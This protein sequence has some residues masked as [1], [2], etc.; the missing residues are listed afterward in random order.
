MLSAGITLGLDRAV[1]A[2]GSSCRGAAQAMTRLELLFGTARADGTRV[3]DADWV[4]FLDAE[5]TPRFP[6]GLTVLR[7]AGQWR[8]SDGR[9]TKED[10]FVLLVWHKTGATREADIEAIRAAYRAR[11]GQS[12]VLRVDSLSCVS[13]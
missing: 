11:F 8:E 2:P 3:A 9:L 13:F 10:A 12:S 1:L 4:A 7:G 6:S 5:I